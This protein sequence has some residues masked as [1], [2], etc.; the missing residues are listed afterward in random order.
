MKN[1]EIHNGLLQNIIRDFLGHSLVEAQD[2]RDKNIKEIVSYR[3]DDHYEWAIESDM[4]QIEYLQRNILITRKFQA[5]LE[6]IKSA[7]WDEFDVSNETE[8]DIKN[9][10]MPFIGTEAE[11]NDLLEIIN[12]L[13]SHT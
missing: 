4:K 12:I 1:S 2:L 10:W 8:Q 6:L 3:N 5:I 11:Y 13:N 7:G 9:K